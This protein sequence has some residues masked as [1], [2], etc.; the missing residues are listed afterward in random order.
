MTL[1]PLSTA[2]DGCASDVRVNTWISEVSPTHPVD[3]FLA[4]TLSCFVGSIV[5]AEA[6]CQLPTELISMFVLGVH[7]VVVPFI[8]KLYSRSA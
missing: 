6:V 3:V 5:G 8:I 7:P 2:N 4:T 1:T